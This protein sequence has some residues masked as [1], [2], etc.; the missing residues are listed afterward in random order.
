MPIGAIGS[1]VA[2][3][4]ICPGRHHM[5]RNM[6]TSVVDI[7]GVRVLA[8]AE[9]ARGLAISRYFEP[10]LT[11]GRTARYSRNECQLEKTVVSGWYVLNLS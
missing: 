1:R 8:H 6:S 11:L 9:A 4:R 2:T 3:E 7:L 5:L 10:S